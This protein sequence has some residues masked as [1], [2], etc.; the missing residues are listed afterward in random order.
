MGGRVGGHTKSGTL[1]GHGHGHVCSSMN[2]ARPGKD[3]RHETR[4]QHLWSCCSVALCAWLLLLK[5]PWAPEKKWIKSLEEKTETVGG[6]VNHSLTYV[7]RGSVSSVQRFDSSIQGSVSY[8][9]GSVS[10]IQGSVSSIQEPVLYRVVCLQPQR[11]VSYTQAS[12]S[13][14][15]TCPA[16]TSVV[17]L[18]LLQLLKTQ[19]LGSE[20]CW[21][22]P[23][24]STLGR[25]P[26]AGAVEGQF[27]SQ[28]Q[29]K[30][31]GRVLTSPPMCAGAGHLDFVLTHTSSYRLCRQ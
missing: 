27:L 19:G 6:S 4:D 25:V 7:A 29:R 22:V 14:V 30:R 8:I 12:D 9:Q 24:P 10:Y 15:Q 21:F 3:Y 17:L 16:I 1:P 18:A 5:P 28:E 2:W 20:G 31:K 13:S 26:R 23:F 11:S